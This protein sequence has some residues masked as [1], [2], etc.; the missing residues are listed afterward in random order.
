MKKALILVDMQNDFVHKEGSLTLPHDTSKLIEDMTQFV[1]DFDGMLFFTK[2]THNTDACEFKLFPKHCVEDTW[3]HNIVESLI[4]AVKD[5]S[6]S[7][8]NKKSFSDDKV[9]YLGDT[10]MELGIEEIHVVGVCTHIC[11]HD[12]V[13]GLVN[14]TKSKYNNT[15][16]FI[17]HRNLVDDFDQDMSEFAL[18]RLQ[19]LYGVD[20]KN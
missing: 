15:P 1:K 19:N 3:G 9:S 2:D 11:V 6:H 5:R 16:K 17:I 20:I 4:Y 12:V 13:S 8:I 14:Y 18:K 7:V 10:F